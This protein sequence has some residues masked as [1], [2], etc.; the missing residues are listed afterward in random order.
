MSRL[1]FSSRG[2]GLIEVLIA[3]FLVTVG[4]L[5]ILSMQPSAWR[6]AG[7]SDFLGR[8]AGIL[9]RELE[10]RESWIMNS[11]NTVPVGVRPQQTIMTSDSLGTFPG[12]AQYT[13]QTSINPVAGSASAWTVTVTV[14]WPDQQARG[15][16]NLSESLVVTRQSR[17]DFPVGCLP[18]TNA[19]PAWF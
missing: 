14:T 10:L 9:H 8:G 17:F 7:K 6:A 11:C 19:P 18:N 3:I 5:A 1:V 4:V 15:Y 13:V 2:I 16:R 12:D